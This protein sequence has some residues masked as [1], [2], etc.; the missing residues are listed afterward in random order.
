MQGISGR[1]EN[2]RVAD[3][4][5]T[6]RIR[7]L[8]DEYKAPYDGE[9]IVNALHTCPHLLIIEDG[10]ETP[11]DTI[12]DSPMSPHRIGQCVR[13][14]G[15]AANNKSAFAANPALDRPIRIDNAGPPQLCQF[16]IVI[17]VANRLCDV[18][19]VPLASLVTITIEPSWSPTTTV[20]F[21]KH[22]DLPGDWHI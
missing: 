6:G 10:I 11:M 14:V 15:N 9:V 8:K 5:L 1:G 13:S 16:A 22:F 18:A 12:L 17:L 3:I 19:G 20:P 21:S 2:A 4:S 7:R